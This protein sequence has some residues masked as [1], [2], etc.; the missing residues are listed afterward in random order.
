MTYR[1]ASRTG[2]TKPR[3]QAEKRAQGHVVKNL[4]MLGFFVSSFSQAR[5]S[6][7]TPGI[8]DLFVCH[9]RYG[10]SLWIEM[11]APGKEK[12]LSAAQAVWH[13]EARAAGQTVIVASSTADVLA[14]LQRMG[15][16]IQ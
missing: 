10:V 6:K 12:N 5:A 15:V 7:Q 8:P 9:A 14:E 4:R 3:N 2:T 16:P 1:S 11:K 13:R